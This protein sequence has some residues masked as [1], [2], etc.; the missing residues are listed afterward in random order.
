M[1]K[2]LR[3]WLDGLLSIPV[4]AGGEIQENRLQEWSERD[5]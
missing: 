4:D 5:I 2:A 3:H 1:L